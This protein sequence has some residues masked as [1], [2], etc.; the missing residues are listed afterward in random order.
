MQDEGKVLAFTMAYVNNDTKEMQ[1][2]DY[3]LRVKSKSGKTFKVTVAD[4]DKSISSVAASSSVNVTYYAVVDQQTALKDLLFQVVEWDFNAANY[5]RMLGQVTYDVNNRVE[6]FQGKVM[7]YDKTKVKGAVK[8]Y[9]VSQ[10]EQNAFVTINFLLENVGFSVTDMSKAKFY[11]QTDGLTVF[12]AA[13]DK[14]AEVKLQPKERKIISLYTTLPLEVA[15]KPLSLIVAV[16]N[17]DTITLPIATFSVPTSKPAAAAPVNQEKL[18]YMSGQPI[19]AMAKEAFASGIEGVRDLQIEYVLK[20]I[21]STVVAQPEMEFLVKAKDGT[22]YPLTYAKEEGNNIL[23]K[24]DKNIPLSGQVPEEIDLDASELVVYT[25]SSQ[26]VRY[27]L[28][29][30]EIKTVQQEGNIGGTFNYDDYEIMVNQ[31]QRT[32]ADDRDYIAADI[33]VKNIGKTIKKIPELGGF[34][35]INGVRIGADKTTSVILDQVISLSPGQSFNYVV[36][37]DIPFTTDVS[38]VVFGLTEKQGETAKT[39]YQFMGQFEN[40]IPVTAPNVSYKIDKLGQSAE[41]SVIKSAIY[42]GSKTNMYYVELEYANTESRSSL[43]AKL[44]GYLTNK[45]GAVVPITFDLYDQK[46]FPNGTILVTG[47]GRIPKQFK[48]EDTVLYLGQSVGDKDAV[49][50]ASGV[51]MDTMLKGTQN[52]FSNIAVGSYLLSFR[53]FYPTID[54]VRDNAT[55]AIEVNG[56]KLAF[57]YDLQKA[58][59]YE[60]NVDEHKFLLEFIDEKS[61]K[62]V[63]K[64]EKAF[65]LNID[66]NEAFVLKEGEGQESSIILQD[67]DV[68]STLVNYQNYTINLYHLKDDTK[69][70]VASRELKW[71][72]K[73]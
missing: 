63:Y 71:Y 7:I 68:L 11:I 73:E 21:G 26:G 10:D 45:D 23:P 8:Q 6:P 52:D 67:K 54:S 28:S 53:N 46:V 12:E 31:I 64:K 13:T 65:V 62:T 3:W 59:N 1:L 2:G 19:H 42:E 5:E 25:T 58:A 33:Q 49:I 4:S 24:I 37:A 27:L 56:I 17:T 34:F 44:G 40:R 43:P 32:S 18:I 66:D 20:N 29:S 41:V 36:Y 15:S 69:Y 48:H 16:S 9:T 51:R 72:V 22:L 61:D 55:G 47:A 60:N 39:L 38:S 50:K 35:L 14:L 70:L 57:T 30:H